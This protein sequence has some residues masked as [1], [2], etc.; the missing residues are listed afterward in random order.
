MTWQLKHFI[1][2]KSS[3][4]DVVSKTQISRK[5]SDSIVFIGVKIFQKFE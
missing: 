1:I 4:K 5:S 2:F 3:T